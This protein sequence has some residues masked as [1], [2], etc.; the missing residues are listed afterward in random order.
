[1]K[2]KLKETLVLLSADLYELLYEKTN[3]YKSTV[4]EIVSLAEEFEKK[5][6]W[7]DDDDRDYI[8]ELEKFEDS[9][10]QSIK[11]ENTELMKGLKEKY[12]GD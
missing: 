1:M 7:K 2:E 8:E 9:I 5:L 11:Q 4:S 10:I 3:D 12:Y 6:D